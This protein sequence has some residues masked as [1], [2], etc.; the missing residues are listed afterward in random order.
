MLLAGQEK[1]AVWMRKWQSVNEPNWLLGYD[2]KSDY[3]R[4]GR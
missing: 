3:F 2:Q 1:Q 4:F